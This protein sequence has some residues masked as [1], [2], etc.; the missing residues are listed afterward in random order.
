MALACPV[1]RSVV[2]DLAKF[3]PVCGT[4]IAN[5]GYP[6]FRSS[7]G[8]SPEPRS[9]EP[10]L[11]A[12]ATLELGFGRVVIGSHIGDGGM[13]AVHR[14]W[15]YF[16]PKGPQRSTPPT[17]VAVKL[18]H[19]SLFS[20]ARVRKLFAGEAE[21]LRRLSHPNIVRFYGLSET[22]HQLAIVMELVEGQALSAVIERHI[23]RAQRGGLPAMP[24]LRAWHY[25][26]QLLGALAATHELGIVHRDV[27]PANL[28]IRRDG[29]AKLTDYGIARLPADVARTT[30]SVQPGTGA[31]MSP[32]QVLGEP[33]DG[34]S[35]LYSA[36]IV[37]YEM[38]S[39]R[40]PFE[41]PDR[42]E[43][44]IRAAQV[45]E[46]P[47]RMT[48]LV[49]QAPPVI[50]QLFARG[51]A[52]NPGDR[53]STA[54][55]LGNAFRMALNLPDTMGWQA[56]QVLAGHAVGIAGAPSVRRREG[57]IPVPPEEANAMRER[58]NTAYRGS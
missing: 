10:P 37:L 18:L 56:Q 17:E 3:C 14:A 6:S 4:Q 16:D 9:S 1:C 43:F 33:L 52:K 12:G 29:L 47:R 26:Q 41:A 58:V 22:A 24:F 48:E 28:L 49:P 45:E 2:P 53:F 39:G 23:Q 46:Q 50:D 25:F 38:V 57:T 42:S 35:D 15:L 40:T 31:Y 11:A 44:V 55:E 27:K 32:E 51:L 7:G 13:G 36:A 54:I 34:R 21:A 19:P 5:P 20:R 8:P 30:G